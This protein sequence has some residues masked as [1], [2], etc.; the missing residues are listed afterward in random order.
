MGTVRRKGSAYAPRQ[1]EHQL[2]G[3][4]C[5]VN[6]DRTEQGLRRRTCRNH[7]SDGRRGAEQP[8]ASKSAP[9][10]KR[11]ETLNEP[12]GPAYKVQKIS[13]HLV[14]SERDPTLPIA[15]LQHH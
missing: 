9:E 10:R 3:L 11:T 8:H 12:F 7:A 15:E 5:A 1:L 14:R 4:L 2:G 6:N 13:L